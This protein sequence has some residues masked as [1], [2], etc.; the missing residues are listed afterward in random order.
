M[1]PPR[2]PDHPRHDPHLVAAG[3]AGDLADSRER[4]AFEALLRDCA[5]CAVLATDLGHL[6]AAVHSLPPRPLPAGRDFRLDAAQAARLRRRG[7]LRGLLGPLA[8][9]RVDLRPV[10]GALAALGA[11]GLIL[12][13]GFPALQGMAG[14][15]GSLVA[16]DA[17][18]ESTTRGNGSTT[19]DVVAGSS[20]PPAAPGAASPHAPASSLSPDFAD[21]N[22]TGGTG[23]GKG[24]ATGGPGGIAAP[25][26]QTTPAY[27]PTAPAPPAPAPTAPA[28]PSLPLLPLASLVVLAAGVALWVLGLAARRLG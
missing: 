28:A 8:G 18:T 3:A 22:A 4:T 23:S 25:S 16:R 26:S 13:A 10:G 12:T 21:Q 24:S 20:A 11:A 1:T 9:A 7:W 5:D 14:G 17:T 15:A 19:G 6:R 27:G 2:N